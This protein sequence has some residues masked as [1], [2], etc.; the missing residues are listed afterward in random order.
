MA[1]LI[2]RHLAQAGLA[3]AVASLVLT[4][5]NASIWTVMG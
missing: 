2:D 3:D 1:P 5:D 4:L